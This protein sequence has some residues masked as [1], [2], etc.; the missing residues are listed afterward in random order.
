[1]VC[2]SCGNIDAFPRPIGRNDR[3][4]RARPARSG[5][6]IAVQDINAAGGVLA[7]KLRL[8]DSG[9]PAALVTPSH[10]PGNDRRS[11]KS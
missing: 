9:A 11:E 3:G 10:H 8:F 1:M 5:A 2:T 6:E 4:G 7:M